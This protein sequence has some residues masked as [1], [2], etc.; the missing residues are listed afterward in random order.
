MDNRQLSDL[1][2]LIGDLSEI[3]GVPKLWQL[4]ETKDCELW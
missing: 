2:I 4:N 3:K 1:F